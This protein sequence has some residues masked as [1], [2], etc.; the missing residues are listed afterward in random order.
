MSY[1][2]EEDGIKPVKEFIGNLPAPA[3][4]AFFHRVN[5]YLREQGPATERS[6]LHKV[7]E[8]WQL[9]W[10]KYRVLMILEGNQFVLLYA[11]T[12]SSQRTKPQDIDRA[13]RNQQKHQKKVRKDENEF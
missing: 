1:F 4:A 10:A 5:S 3:R 2:E 11:F 8:F 12:K 9:S 7:E 6:I 13:R